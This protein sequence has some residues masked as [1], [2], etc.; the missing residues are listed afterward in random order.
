[1]SNKPTQG[2]INY[3]Y[4]INTLCGSTNKDTSALFLNK[5]VLTTSIFNNLILMKIISIYDSYADALSTAAFATIP[6]IA[7]GMT[8]HTV[9]LY[10]SAGLGI[11]FFTLFLIRFVLIIRDKV[12]PRNNRL[13]DNVM[14]LLLFP[15]VAALAAMIFID[16]GYD[17]TI[18]LWMALGIAVGTVPIARISDDYDS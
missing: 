2:I 10:V 18:V 8:G 7:M 6:F 4:E 15:Y 17:T 11:M 9:L 3:Q 16:N 13:L 1:M 12:K 14:S 5:E